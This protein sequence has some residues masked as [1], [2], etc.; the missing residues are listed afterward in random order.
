MQKLT[1]LDIFAGMGGFRLALEAAGFQCSGYVEIDRNVR[2]TYETNFDTEGEWT[3]HD[4]TKITDGEI[5]VLGRERRIDAIVGGFPCQAFSIAGQRRG[6]S[7][8]R[9][10]LFFDLCRFVRGIR[11]RFLI[12]ENVKGLLSHDAGRTF[13]TILHTLD[14]LGYAVEW[15]V[16]NSKDHGVPQNRERVI[17][18]GYLGRRSGRKIFPLAGE[19]GAA[20]EELVG[21]RQGMRV[22]NPAGVSCTLSANGGGFGTCTGLYLVSASKTGLKM[23]ETA[24]CLVASYGK[25]LGAN[26]GRPGVLVK[27]VSAPDKLKK[28]QNGRRVK[29]EGDPMFTLTCGDCHGVLLPGARIRKLTPLECFRL[30]AFPDSHCHNARRAGISDS[31]LYKQAGNAVTV[32]VIYSVAKKLMENLGGK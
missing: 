23:R 29:G 5:R 19:N 18:V 17:L 28:R 14:E 22:C 13:L 21:G 4:I 11:P 20:L 1:F 8:P 12:L 6:F 26:Q 7:D 24:D 30:Q 32:S 25:G 10:S 15:Q 3:G 16:L 9:G 27:A 31:Q 2:R